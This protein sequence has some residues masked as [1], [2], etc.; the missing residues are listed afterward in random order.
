MRAYLDILRNV[1]INGKY[2]KD[3]TGVGRH[4]NF[5]EVFRHDLNEGFPLLTTK[6]VHFKSVLVEL[7]WFLSGDTNIAF[8]KKHGVS[9]WDEWSDMNGDLGAIYGHQWRN[10]SNS[11]GES[12]VDQISNVIAEI[13]ANPN[14]SRLVVNSWN[15]SALPNMKLPPCHYT[16]Q[17]FVLDG[18]L[19]CHAHMRSADL[20]L[21]VPFNIASYAL[22]THIIAYVCDLQVGELVLTMTDC[23]IYANHLEQVNKQLKRELLTL[24]KLKIES[25]KPRQ[26]FGSKGELLFTIDD[27]KLEDYVSHS[28]I[29]AKVAV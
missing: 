3:R 8:L 2:S 15:V 24:P 14:S 11:V 1:Y 21:G 7:L 6:E 25:D 18:V 4:R 29:K 19:S 20:F 16:F 5:F 17:F 9:I 23:H 10:W 22:L 26:L 13:K 27:F 12:G 28:K